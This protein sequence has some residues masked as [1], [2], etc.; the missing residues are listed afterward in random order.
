MTREGREDGSGGG[1]C[2]LD[3]TEIISNLENHISKQLGLSR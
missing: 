2:S 1:T 3:R